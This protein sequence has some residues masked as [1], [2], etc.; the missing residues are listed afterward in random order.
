M[1]LHFYKYISI[2]GKKRDVFSSCLCVCVHA[3]VLS[4]FSHIQLFVT[5]WTVA[6][7]APLS[8]GC[9]RQEYWSGLPCS[10]SV[11]LPD[12]EIKLV[13]LTSPALAG[14]LLTTGT[15]W[16]AP[17]AISRWFIFSF[18][19]LSVSSKC[20]TVNTDYFHNP[21]EKKIQIADIVIKNCC[22]LKPV[23]WD[24][25]YRKVRNQPHTS[26]LSWPYASNLTVILLQ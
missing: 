9:S 24:C 23:F 5:S 11:D 25:T 17:V 12:P 18:L 8:M 7:Q 2:G 10:P 3:C 14:G 16:E 13:S 4:C 19:C 26:F 20:S 15:T 21:K 22:F 1:T 6:C